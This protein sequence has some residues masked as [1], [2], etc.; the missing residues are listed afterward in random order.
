M[1]EWATETFIIKQAGFS[2]SVACFSIDGEIIATGGSETGTIKLWRSENGLCFASFDEHEAPISDIAFLPKG[3]AIISAS[4]D[5]SLRAFDL[6]KYRAFRKYNA[7]E[8]A[9]LLCLALDNS[10]ELVVA[11]AR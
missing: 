4:L 10:G 3:N 9:Q 2:A 5:G 8:N 7:P 1:W 6:V 11:G